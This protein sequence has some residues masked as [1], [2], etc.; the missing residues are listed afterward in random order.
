MYGAFI[1]FLGGMCIVGYLCLNIFNRF[2]HVRDICGDFIGT[3]SKFIR[4]GGNLCHY[5][6]EAVV[7]VFDPSAGIHNV[8]GNL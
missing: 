5:Y 1:H 2:C 6:F 7:L 4:G 8:P 3:D